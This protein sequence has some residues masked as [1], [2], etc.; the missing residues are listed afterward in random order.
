MR[1]Q[2]AFTL[3]ELLVVIAIIAILMAILMPALQKAKEQAQSSSCQGNLKGF[4]LAVPM[5]AQDN[6][7]KF[8][9]SDMCYF[10]SASALPGEGLTGS[11]A[12]HRRWCNGN[13][14]LKKHPEFGGEFFKY[15][16]DVRGLICPTFKGLAKHRDQQISKNVQFATGIATGVDNYDPWHNYTQNGY[17]G[18]KK[19]DIQRTG[20]VQKTGQVKQPSE[21]IVFADEGPYV[22]TGYNATG[23]NDTRLYVIFGSQKAIDQ[24]KIFRSKYNIT[25]GPDGTYG[26]FTDVIAGFHNAPSGNV[27][28][29]KGNC[30]FADGHVAPVSRLDSFAVA[31]PK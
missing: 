14:N 29:G 31:W 6:D 2:R 16:G 1:N 30:S 11:Q 20:I 17:L 12:L 4:S 23:L 10:R 25:T 28:A 15:L 26:Q 8:P 27:V 13:V 5:Y 21:L 3:I 24:M 9:D 7:D 22:E 19:S 18:P